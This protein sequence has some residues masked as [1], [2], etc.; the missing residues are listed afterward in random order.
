MP[1]PTT[2]PTATAMPSDRLSARCRWD[3]A[4]GGGADV[5]DADVGGCED[6]G[7]PPDDGGRDE[8]GGWDDE[9]GDR[10]EGGGRPVGVMTAPSEVRRAPS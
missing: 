1:T 8:D 4:P 3:W 7:R 9:C 6:A 2:E 10:E 5:D